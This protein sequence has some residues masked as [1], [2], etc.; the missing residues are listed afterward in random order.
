[1]VASGGQ[2]TDILSGVEKV[3]DG[4]GHSFLLV[5]SGGFATIQEAI[6]AAVAGDTVLVAN[7]SYTENVTLKS[8]VSLSG[9][10]EAGVVIHGTMLTPAS[11]D[12][13]T[14][15]NLTVQNVGDTMLL[16]MRAT[17]E[18]TDAVFDHVTFSLSGDF[19]GAVPIGNGQISGSIAIHDGGDAGQAGLTFQHV[20]MASNNHLAGSTA[21]V[22]TTTDSIGGAKMVLDDVTL[23]GTAAAGGLGAQWNMTNGTGRAAVDI[24]P[25]PGSEDTELG[26]ILEPEV[27]YGTQTLCTRIQA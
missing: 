26:V 13:A 27:V 25:A 8:G 19:T 11:F 14:V 5:G 4:T 20:T 15:S 12:N 10:S 22:F 21:F 24:W 23:T 2:G 3:T 6:N 7:G 16:D 18:I 9:Q 17:S 1:M